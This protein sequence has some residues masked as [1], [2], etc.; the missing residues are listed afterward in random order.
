M[1]PL[2][3]KHS[4][5]DRPVLDVGSIRVD[6]PLLNKETTRSKVEPICLASNRELD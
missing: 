1:P 6:P 2:H 4:T 3:F 5:D